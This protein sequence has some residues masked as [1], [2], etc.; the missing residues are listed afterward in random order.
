MRHQCAYLVISRWSL[1]IINWWYMGIH[2]QRVW[3]AFR[4]FDCRYC[5]THHWHGRA[6]RQ[7]W[8]LAFRRTT[9]FVIFPPS[10]RPPP[11]CLPH[12][13]PYDTCNNR[14]GRASVTFEQ[15]NVSP[16]DRFGDNSS[17]PSTSVK[18]MKTQECRCAGVSNMIVYYNQL[19]HGSICGFFYNG[20]FLLWAILPHFW[21]LSIVLGTNSQCI[22][23]GQIR[24]PRESGIMGPIEMPFGMFVYLRDLTK[25]PKFHHV[26]PIGRGP[27]RGRNT[28]VDSC[29]FICFYCHCHCYLFSPNSSAGRRVL[30]RANFSC[31][32]G[33]PL[34]HVPFVVFTLRIHNFGGQG[35]KMG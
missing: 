18:N 25:F 14:Q 24:P 12:N 21:A 29:C 31:L 10:V 11:T 33:A 2:W 16:G 30:V 17:N 19:K 7:L 20:F 32:K 15:H 13:G 5:D 23:I 26:S 1:G 4:R 35:P 9:K 6:E 27:T 8:R 34:V 28:Q 3:V 22:C